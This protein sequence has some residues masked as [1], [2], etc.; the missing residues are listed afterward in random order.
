VPRF[1]RAQSPAEP[2]PLIVHRTTCQCCWFLAEIAGGQTC[3]R[4]EDYGTGLHR[5][6]DASIVM[7]R[8]ESPGSS[9]QLTGS[10]A[11]GAKSDAAY[12]DVASMHGVHG[13]TN[14]I[15]VSTP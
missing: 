4:A 11:D 12:D 1:A 9:G 14:D 13:I 5:L 3:S 10:T 15:V 7:I 2:R 6:S 8:L